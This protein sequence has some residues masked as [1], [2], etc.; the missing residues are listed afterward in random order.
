MAAVAAG[1][2]AGQIAIQVRVE[3]TG[4]VRFEILR[5]ALRRIAQV[6]AAVDDDPA[7]V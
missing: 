7:I 5:L 6:E 1:L 2:L 4:N 3:R